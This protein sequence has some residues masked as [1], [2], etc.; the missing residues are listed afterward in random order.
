MARTNGKPLRGVRALRKRAGLNQHDF[1]NRI[2]VTQ[3]GG[4][5]Y[6][7]GRAIPKPVR[8]LLDLAYSDD[9]NVAGKALARLRAR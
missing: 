8:I 5:R 3:S 6:E 7:N 2:G 1:W 9:P 4:S